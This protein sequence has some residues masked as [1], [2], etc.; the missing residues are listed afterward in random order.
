MVNLTIDNI[1]VSCKEGT[2]I[3]DAAA[4]IGIPIPHL[5]YLKG[6]NEIAACRVCVVEVRGTE[7]L[8]PACDNAVA[9]G[10]TIFTN[11]PRVRETRRVNVELLMSQHSGECMSCVRSGNCSLQTLANDLNILDDNPF[12][13]DLPRFS[14]TWRHR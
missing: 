7:R 12:Q 6:V 8:V 11:S 9:E 3:M 4:S 14:G 5:C 13:K 10:M 1:P 2:T